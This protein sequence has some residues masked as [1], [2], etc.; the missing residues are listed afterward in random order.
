MIVEGQ[1][2]VLAVSLSSGK[3][4]EPMGVEDFPAQ[5]MFSL[6][7]NIQRRNIDRDCPNP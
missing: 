4:E 1:F 3:A 5:I 6:R 2:H 7:V